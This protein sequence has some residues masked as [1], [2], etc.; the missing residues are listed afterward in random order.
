MEALLRDLWR[1]IKVFL[2]DNKYGRIVKFFLPFFGQ[3]FLGAI[4]V[5]SIEQWTPIE[6]LY[7]AAVT[8]TTVG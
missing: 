2:K 7:W 3:W 4:V 8:L 5:G 1:S 6:S